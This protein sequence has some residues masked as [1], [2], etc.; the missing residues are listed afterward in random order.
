MGTMFVANPVAALR[1]VRRSMR[2]DGRICLVV[3]RRKLENEW[4]YR[5]EQA[6]EEWVEEEED[7]DE[8]TCGPGP[9]A[10]ANADTVSQQLIAAGFDDVGF[11]RVDIDMKIGDD[12]E[13][14]V[15]FVCALGPAGEAIRLAGEQG[16]QVRPQVEAAVREVLEPYVKVGGGVWGPATSWVVTAGAASQ[17]S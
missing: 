12:L 1:N 16:R 4:M 2:P 6:V 5:A 17:G 3:W 7:S 9:F 13:H 14:A 15:S 10:Q 8:L 11:R